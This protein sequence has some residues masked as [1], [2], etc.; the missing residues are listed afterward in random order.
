MH[1]IRV[2]CLSLA[3]CANDQ[4]MLKAEHFQLHRSSYMCRMRGALGPALN[5]MVN[6]T[7][8]VE[9]GALRPPHAKWYGP[10]SR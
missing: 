8:S 1:R 7:P 5:G 2:E 9:C 10:L 6:L 4:D 3:R